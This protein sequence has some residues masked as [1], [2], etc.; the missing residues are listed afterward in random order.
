MVTRLCM[1]T[2]VTVREYLEQE[3]DTWRIQDNIESPVYNCWLYVYYSLV[4]FLYV[5]AIVCNVLVSC[6]LCVMM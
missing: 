6:I 2:H 3:K 4:C 5:C 1:K